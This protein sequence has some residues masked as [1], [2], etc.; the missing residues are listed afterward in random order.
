LNAEKSRGTE[1][2]H[3]VGP[4]GLNSKKE[5]A[6]GEMRAWQR[7]KHG[8]GNDWHLL[9]YLGGGTSDLRRTKKKT[10][11]QGI[12]FVSLTL[13]VCHI[14][15]NKTSKTHGEGTNAENI[16]NLLTWETGG[17]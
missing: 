3:G 12:K 16:K 9:N 15:K 11:R 4:L 2:N 17:E 1:L 14:N 13:E 5:R 6:W 8:A 10:K 7:G